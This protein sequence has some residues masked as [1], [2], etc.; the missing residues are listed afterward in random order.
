MRERPDIIASVVSWGDTVS[1][2]ARDILAEPESVPNNAADGERH[3]AAEFLTGFLSDGPKPQ[4]EVKE[5]AEA[6]CHAWRT[7]RRAQKEL[8]I[9]PSKSTMTGGWV[10]SLPEDG[11]QNAKM[12]TN[13]CLKNVATFGNVGHLRG[14]SEAVSD[15]LNGSLG[16]GWESEI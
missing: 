2:N 5:A 10:W 16:D 6:N 15:D 11:H 7:I 8:G 13:P 12:A 3:E 4:K 1:G 9:N 14:V